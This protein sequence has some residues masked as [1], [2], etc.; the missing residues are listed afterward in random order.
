[1]M[2]RLMRS[3]GVVLIACSLSACAPPS[4]SS[5]SKDPAMSSVQEDAP[6][7]A[8]LE[9]LDEI[10]ALSDLGAI[11]EGATDIA[12]T[13]AVK[14]AESYPTGWG[15]VVSY[16]ADDEA[17]RRY[18]DDYT[19]HNSAIIDKYPASLDE[20]KLTQIGRASCRERV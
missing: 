20:H 14:F 11:P 10:L 15:Y 18:V 5:D 12:V 17:I 6:Y 3:A 16:R 13:P 8:D 2:N 9:H 7:P 19:S 4:P 1:M